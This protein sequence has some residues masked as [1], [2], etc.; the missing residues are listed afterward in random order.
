DG[1][2]AHH[3]AV[4]EQHE[5]IDTDLS[6]GGVTYERIAP[7]QSWRITAASEF[8]VR[9]LPSGDDAGT[10]P[11]EADVTF[12]A[13]MPAI[14]GDGQGRSG[15]GASAATRQ[16]VGKGHLEQ[17]GRWTGTITIAGTPYELGDAR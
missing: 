4:R 7:M 8:A 2:L 5:M 13:L 1:R 10:V 12:A 6:V 16:S 17:A 9:E 15:A 14:G 11:I 3:G